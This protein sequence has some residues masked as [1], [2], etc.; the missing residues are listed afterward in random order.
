[1]QRFFENKLIEWLKV[2]KALPLMLVAARQTGKTHLL[3]QFCEKKFEQTIYLNFAEEPEYK[4]FFMIK[5]LDLQKINAQYADEFKQAVA[6]VIDKGWFLLGERVKT[7]EHQF[8][9]YIGTKHT[10]ACVNSLDADIRNDYSGQI[11]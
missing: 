4:T 5:F 2:P 9:D 6:E 3:R 1:M 8:C 7:F 11:Q 10:V